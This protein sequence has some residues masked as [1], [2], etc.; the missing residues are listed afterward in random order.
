LHRISF[1][2]KDILFK[3]NFKKA[4]DWAKVSGPHRIMNLHFADDYLWFLA[5]A[6]NCIE[7]LKWILIVF[8]DHLGLKI[9]SNKNEMVSLN[10][11]LNEGQI[12]DNIL[13]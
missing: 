11:I 7:S 3:I 5:A 9:N 12:V 2:T 1:K 4:F 8:E 10:F 13:I 6:S